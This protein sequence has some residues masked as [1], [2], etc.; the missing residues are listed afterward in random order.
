MTTFRRIDIKESELKV[1]KRFCFIKHGINVKYKYI[2]F[3]YEFFEI[4]DTRVVR[5]MM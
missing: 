2:Y 1:Q 5:F 4:K 3:Y